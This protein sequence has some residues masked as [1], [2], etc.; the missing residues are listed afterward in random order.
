MFKAVRVSLLLL[1]VGAPWAAAEN[2]AL[3]VGV[4]KYKTPGNDL[5]GIEN[6]VARMSEAAGQMGFAK[7]QVK[8]LMDSEATFGNITKAL[9]TW[10]VDGVTAQDKVLF[11]FSGHGTYARDANG[12]EPD[13]TDEAILPTDIQVVDKALKNA[14]VDD[15]LGALLD[16]IPTRNVYVFLDSC[17]SGTATRSIG[18]DYV[19]KFFKYDG[20]PTPKPVVGAARG[21]DAPRGGPPRATSS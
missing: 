19:P 18:G 17:H 11:Y 10:L 15:E 12:D 3:I 4:G 9:Q 2:R 1:L 16:R 6:D 14:L 7:S 20:M 5:P 21:L 13:G 8:I